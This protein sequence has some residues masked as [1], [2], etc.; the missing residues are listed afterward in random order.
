[1]NGVIRST[2]HYQP[3]TDV[4]TKVMDQPSRDLILQRN[5]DLRKDNAM[6]DLSF[7][8]QVASIPII[9]WEWAIRNGYDLANPNGEIAGKEIF[10]FLRSERGQL[11]MV[12]DKL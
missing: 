12:R 6:S 2:F 1:M 7:G 8:R 4:L 11:C 3:H 10:R 9:D 5:A